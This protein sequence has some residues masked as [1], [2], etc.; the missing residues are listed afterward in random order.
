MSNLNLNRA[1]DSRNHPVP[2]H[3]FQ[4]TENAHRIRSDQEAIEIAQRLAER[5]VQEASQRDQARQL[6]LNE[7][8]AFFAKWPLG[9]YCAKSIWRCWRVIS[10]L[11]RGN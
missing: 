6:P 7:V 1:H 3:Y 5:F 9:H 10:H 2:H 11:G 4:H 8:Q